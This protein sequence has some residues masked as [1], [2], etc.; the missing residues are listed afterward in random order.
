MAFNAQISVFSECRLSS[1]LL[2]MQIPDRDDEL[3]SPETS[4]TSLDDLP[5]S[6]EDPELERE[7]QELA[8]WLLEAFCYQHRQTGKA[9][10]GEIDSGIPA[11]TI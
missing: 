5:S 9:D 3:L 10:A 7:F 8:R 11:V 6:E 4:T 2:G 1:I